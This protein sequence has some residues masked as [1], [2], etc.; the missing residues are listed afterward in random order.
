MIYVVELSIAVLFLG[1]LVVV[2]GT[3]QNADR[4]VQRH[5]DKV[6]HGLELFS[7][8]Q[9]IA[10]VQMKHIRGGSPILE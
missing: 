1:R 5:V 7:R 2:D 10:H 4:F 8:W 3:L 6:N 9:V